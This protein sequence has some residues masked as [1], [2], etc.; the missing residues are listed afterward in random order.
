MDNE[1]DNR[2]LTNHE[3]REVAVQAAQF[4]MQA[5]AWFELCE[6]QERMDVMDRVSGVSGM[7]ELCADQ[8]LAFCRYHWDAMI[9]S[10]HYWDSNDWYGAS[11]D[12]FE[13]RIATVLHGEE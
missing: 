2:N 10:E 3:A 9:G 1:G 11:D 6:I 13:E 8:A 5:L 4:G 7:Y 12:W